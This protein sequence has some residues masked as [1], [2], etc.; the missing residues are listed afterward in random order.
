MD[1]EELRRRYG[2]HPTGFHLQPGEPDPADDSPLATETR[3]L[4]DRLP[5]MGVH[6]TWEQAKAIA[7][8]KLEGTE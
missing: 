8:Q 1:T 5:Q 3:R 6:V 4:R 2:I 7:T